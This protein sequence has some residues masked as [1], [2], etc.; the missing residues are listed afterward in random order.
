MGKR[1]K[2]GVS[3]WSKHFFPYRVIS[4]V[5]GKPAY[6]LPRAF[7]INE[8]AYQSHHTKNVTAH[9]TDLYWQGYMCTAP[10]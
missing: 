10:R 3:L 4:S 5:V 8:E 1:D 6:D 2:E 9:Y 7:L